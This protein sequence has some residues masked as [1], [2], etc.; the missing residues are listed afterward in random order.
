MKSEKELELIYERMSSYDRVY[1]NQ[2]KPPQAEPK[3]ADAISD[4]GSNEPTEEERETAAELMK[5][6]APALK[7]YAGDRIMTSWGSKTP[8]G[9]VRSLKRILSGL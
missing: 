7:R 3:L 9:L 1:D 4:G 5:F 6:L 8:L 2:Q